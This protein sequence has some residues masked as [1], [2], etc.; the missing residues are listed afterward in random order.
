MNSKLQVEFELHCRN[1]WLGFGY[2]LLATVAVLSLIP[3]PDVGGSDKLIHF[4]VYLVISSWFSLIV[5]R[6]R[7][8]WLVI[9]GLIAFGFLME[10]LQGMT[11]YR[12]QDFNDAMANS[13]GVVLGIASRFSPLRRLLMIVDRY[14]YALF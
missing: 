10:Y 4:I 1:I 11:S 2:G 3:G 8:L 13:L 9:F 12:M 7:T 14:L 6:P 5:K